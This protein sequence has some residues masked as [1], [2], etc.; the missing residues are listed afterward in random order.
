MITHRAWYVS[1]FIVI[2]IILGAAV[3]DVDVNVNIMMIIKL[4]FYFLLSPL[5]LELQNIFFEEAV[6]ARRPI[7]LKDDT[8]VF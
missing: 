1:V 8:A 7:F 4:Q 2:Y 3:V 6:L 5:L